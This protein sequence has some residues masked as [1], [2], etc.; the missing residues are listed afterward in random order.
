MGLGVIR[1]HHGTDNGDAGDAFPPNATFSRSTRKRPQRGSLRPP[2]WRGLLPAEFGGAGRTEL[3]REPKPQFQKFTWERRLQNCRSFPSV[4][5]LLEQGN[6]KWLTGAAVFFENQRPRLVS[7]QTR[8]RNSEVA[9]D[10][11]HVDRSQYPVRRRVPRGLRLSRLHFEEKAA[12]CPAIH[13][14]EMTDP[15]AA[16]L[17]PIFRACC[18]NSWKSRPRPPRPSSGI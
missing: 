14:L 2:T 17:P 7:P 18:V 8:G 11:R 15:H 9:R 5:V 10:C 6:W 13:A 4:I 3:T 1:Q 12:A 16:L